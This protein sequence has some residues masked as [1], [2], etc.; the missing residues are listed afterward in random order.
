MEELRNIINNVQ[1]SPLYYLFLSSKELFHS[2]FWFWIYRIDPGQFAEIFNLEVSQNFSVTREKKLQNRINGELFKSEVDLFI[3]NNGFPN[4]IIENKTKDFPTNAQL[5]RIISSTA[6][7]T[8]IYTLITLFQFDELHFPDWNI[9]SYRDL[10]QNI[11]G[12]DFGNDYYNALIN[13]YAE[14]I[15]NLSDLADILT[16]T[17]NYDFGNNLNP[18]LF[19][20]LDNIKFWEAYVKMRLG[21]FVN[22]Y[23]TNYLYSEE[24]IIESNINRKMPT[25]TWWL[26]FNQDLK[27]G[28]QVE[29]NSYRKAI[30][31][32]NANDIFN[33]LSNNNL[34]F[35]ANW[36]SAR[37]LPYLQYN[38][39]NRGLFIYQ[40]EIINISSFED[41]FNRIN[42]DLGLIEENVLP[43]LNE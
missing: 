29:N 4:I 41:L 2:N 8:S 6:N 27:I 32:P 16:P 21:H 34:F 1:S 14:F 3:E 35:Q 40:S 12:R 23:K 19:S 30:M 25:I 22:K 10:S 24:L 26:T 42:T 31:G 13:D 15:S 20:E 38:V 37:D 7:E 43:Y 28:I 36:R 18:D 17:L 11:N 39:G 33:N 9:M 5:S